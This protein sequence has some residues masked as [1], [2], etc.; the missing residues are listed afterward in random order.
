MDVWQTE[1]GTDTNGTHPGLVQKHAQ[2]LYLEKPSS[3]SSNFVASEKPASELNQWQSD[4]GL[5]TYG[6]FPKHLTQTTAAGGTVAMD[7]ITQQTTGRKLVLEFCKETIRIK[8][9][10]KEAA[11]FINSMEQIIITNKRPITD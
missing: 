8:E 10:G 11:D 2:T 5:L 6:N 9:K 3:T 4:P 7:G 1:K